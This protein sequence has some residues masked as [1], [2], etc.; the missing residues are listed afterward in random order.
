MNA[1][2]AEHALLPDGWARNVRLSWDDAGVLTEVKAGTGAKG[3]LARA[4]GPVLPGMPNLHSHAFQ[5]AMAGLTEYRAPGENDF[6]S[7]RT[8]MYRFA[9]QLRPEELE[10]IAT[11]LYIEMLK[12]GYTSVCEFHYLHHDPQG[13]PYPNRTELAERVLAAAGAA[14]IGVTLLPSLYEHSGFGRRPPLPEQRRFVTAP[15]DLLEMLATLRRAHPEHERLRYGV[16]PHSLRAVSP[17]SLARLVSGVDALD[18]AAPVHIHA[19]EQTGEVA[20]SLAVLGAPPVQWLLDNAALDRRWCLVHATHMRAN[21]SMRVA[22][23]GATVALCPSTEANLG[24]GV[25]EAL[26]YLGAR[27]AWGIGSDSHIS[28][29]VREELRGLECAQRLLHRKR[30]V[31]ADSG[32]P[33]TAEHLYLRAVAGGA[34]ASARPIAGVAVGQQADLLVLDRDGPDCSLKDPALALA[35]WI[36][37]THGGDAVRDVMVG[38]HW[39]VEDGHHAA[40]AR[41]LREYIHARDALLAR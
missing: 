23:S 33:H 14:G 12:C 7:W 21:E 37:G 36:F 25:F 38:G 34:R 20:D 2:F 4:A 9:L 28:V 18:P 39:V 40:E 16:A 6:W 5:R 29:S 19:A 22:A 27:G 31:L 32:S 30:N 10:A 1:L 17:E 11:Q 15:E 35:A 26:A 13:R 3:G 24:D 8:L 41:A